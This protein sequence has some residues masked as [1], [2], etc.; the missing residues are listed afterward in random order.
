MSTPTLKLR[1]GP[2]PK[3][4]QTKVTFSC[5][6][7]LLEDLQHY[8]AQYAQAYGEPIDVAELV[9]HMLVTFMARDR[10]FRR[11]GQASHGPRTTSSNAAASPK[12][13]GLSAAA[14]PRP[15]APAR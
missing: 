8:A 13:A 7:V 12:S 4:S 1:L 5:T 10:A 14:S 11:A 2:R 3:T 9:P 6:T 15:A